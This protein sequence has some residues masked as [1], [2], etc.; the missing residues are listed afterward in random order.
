MARSRSKAY[1]LQRKTYYLDG[2]LYE[3]LRKNRVGRDEIEREYNAMKILT[4]NIQI[5]YN[6]A[7]YN[8]LC[9]KIGRFL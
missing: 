4:P 7:A 2:D 5:T 3:L 6:H 9:K 1:T 8:A